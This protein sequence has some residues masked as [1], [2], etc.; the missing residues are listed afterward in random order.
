MAKVTLEKVSK[1]YGDVEAVKKIDLEITDN[2]FLVLVG[3][4]GCGKSSTLR[5]I[6][7]LE[8]IDEGKII[9]GEKIVN[10]LEPRER[11][12]SMVFQN[13]AL[14]P[15]MT[16]EENLGFSL[17]IAGM[18]KID[19]DTRVFEA[20]GILDIKEFLQRKPAQLSGGQRQRVAMG[21]AIV[22]RPDVFLF[23]E[24]LS[25][26]DA[27][28]RNQMRTEIKRLHQ[29][30]E[31]TIVYVTHDQ[32]EAMTLADRIVIMKDGIIEQIGTPLELFETPATKFVATFIGSP[33][34]NIISSTIEKD[35]G[36]H[37]MKT[38]DGI[39]IPVPVSKQDTVKEGQKISFGFRAEDIVPLKFGNKPSQSWDY[40]S[41]VNLSEPL[42]TETLIFT[43]FGKIEIVS[44][45]FTPELVRA[46]DELDFALNLDR[47]YLFDDETGKAL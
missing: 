38:E 9:I 8:E 41:K 26:L 27:K 19:I 16:V 10:E 14:Y 47:T 13:Y 33:S 36:K 46:G 4:S 35:Q 18:K 42:G 37:V 43:N 7:G 25:N 17:K 5:M 34:M 45:M 39:S 12:V 20:A 44:R 30:V 24:P 15:H 1:F 32:V 3:P 21:R 11:N 40:K 29:K 31:T 23:D 6:A 22:R 2:E 28:L